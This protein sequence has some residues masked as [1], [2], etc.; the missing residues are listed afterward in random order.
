LYVYQ[1]LQSHAKRWLFIAIAVIATLG[2]LM[3]GFV[4]F[5]FVLGLS[6][7]R[8]SVKGKSAPPRCFLP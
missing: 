2:F 7:L 1:S 5:V 3:P 6:T 8:I 4:V